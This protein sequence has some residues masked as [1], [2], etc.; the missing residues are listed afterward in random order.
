MAVDD[1]VAIDDERYEAGN[2]GLSDGSVEIC[3]DGRGVRELLGRNSRPNKKEQSRSA[4]PRDSGD[5]G[6][7][8]VCAKGR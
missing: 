1:S 4:D 6:K 7:G 3:V 2:L 8:K 5:E